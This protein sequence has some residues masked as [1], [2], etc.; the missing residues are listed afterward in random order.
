MYAEGGNIRVCT[1][2]CDWNTFTRVLC[3]FEADM[4]YHFLIK[5]FFRWVNLNGAPRIYINK[6]YPTIKT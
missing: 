4:P 5:Q 1:C 3:N 6:T 2:S